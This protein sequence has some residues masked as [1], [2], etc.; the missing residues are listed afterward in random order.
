MFITE[1]WVNKY[2]SKAMSNT[3]GYYIDPDLRPDRKDT[4][5]GI[6]GGLIFYINNGLIVK[7]LSRIILINLSNSKLLTKTT[8]VQLIV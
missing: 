6:S 4:L 8:F 3:E 2:S 5:N 7:A 1:T